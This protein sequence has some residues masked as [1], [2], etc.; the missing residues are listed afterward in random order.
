MFSTKKHVLEKKKKTITILRQPA[1]LWNKV[2][3]SLW[4]HIFSISYGNSISSL[5]ICVHSN[6]VWNS[7]PKTLHDEHRRFSLGVRFQRP[8]S[9]G[10]L[11]EPKRNFIMFTAAGCGM[12]MIGDV[13]NSSFFSLFPQ[14]NN[15]WYYF[16]GR[17]WWR[18]DLGYTVAYGFVHWNSSQW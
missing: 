1:S 18:H 9:I 7:S 2:K 11:W 16:L 15:F 5:L 8:V 4:C 14:G 3:I 17:Y 6:S 13:H 10:N 12:L